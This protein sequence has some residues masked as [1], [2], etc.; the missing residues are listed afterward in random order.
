MIPASRVAPV[1]F[2]AI[3]FSRHTRK[4]GHPEPPLPYRPSWP[5]DYAGAPSKKR[6]IVGLLGATDPQFHRNLEEAEKLQKRQAEDRK[7]IAL[8]AF[9]EPRA[10]SRKAIGTATAQPC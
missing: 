1:I 9:E 2:I 8:D 3:S 5:S 6:E 10:C 7:V 4:S